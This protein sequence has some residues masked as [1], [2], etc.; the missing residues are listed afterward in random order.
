MSSGE[1]SIAICPVVP[2]LS[3]ARVLASR[4]SDNGYSVRVP[5]F[6]EW[7]PTMKMSSLEEMAIDEFGSVFDETTAAILAINAVR[8]SADDTDFCETRGIISSRLL[9]CIRIAYDVAPENA[10]LALMYP[11]DHPDNSPGVQAEVTAMDPW[12]LNGDHNLLLTRLNQEEI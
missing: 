9:D 5:G 12:I 8:L 7:S 3:D 1:R 10:A 11:Y 6:V 4:F 2:S